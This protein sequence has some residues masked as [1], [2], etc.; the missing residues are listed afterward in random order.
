ML[1]PMTEPLNV[2]IG[3]NAMYNRYNTDSKIIN[4]DDFTTCKK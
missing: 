1:E 3:I 2:L 4:I